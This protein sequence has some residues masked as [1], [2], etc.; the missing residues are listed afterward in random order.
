MRYNLRSRLGVHLSRSSR[1]RGAICDQPHWN[2][3]EFNNIARVKLPSAYT[4]VCD[5]NFSNHL[6]AA[7]GRPNIDA[8]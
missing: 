5:G 8:V 4:V 6:L 3:C 7:S 1:T 2:G